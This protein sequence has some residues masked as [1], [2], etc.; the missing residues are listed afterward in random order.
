MK[1]AQNQ[2]HF[3][4]ELSEV[5]KAWPALSENARKGVLSL[6]RATNRPSK[7]QQ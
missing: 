5:I 6:V 2:A 3:P 7:D 1:A 4:P